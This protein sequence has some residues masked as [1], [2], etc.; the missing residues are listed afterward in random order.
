MEEVLRRRYYHEYLLLRNEFLNE[1]ANGA[2]WDTL[3]RIIWQMKKLEQRY[4]EVASS[5]VD[6][7]AASAA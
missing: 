2:D 1:V 7:T 4:E 6:R 5:Y 3:K